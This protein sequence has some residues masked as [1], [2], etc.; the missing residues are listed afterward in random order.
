MT[1]ATDMWSQVT[2]RHVYPG[3]GAAVEA[4]KQQHD[5]HG[6]SCKVQWQQLVTRQEQIGL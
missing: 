2:E 5:H 3:I 4:G 6:T 1:P